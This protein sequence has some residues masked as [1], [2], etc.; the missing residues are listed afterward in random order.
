MTEQV[1]PRWISVTERMPEPLVRVLAA[2]PIHNIVEIDM[3]FG[4]GFH[5]GYSH[6]MPLV[7]FPAIE[8]GAA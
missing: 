2:D 4:Q 3:W 5:W 1:T 8:Q 7:E 6:W